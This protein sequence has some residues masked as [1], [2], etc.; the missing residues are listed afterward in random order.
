MKMKSLMIG[1]QIL[2]IIS[3]TE[4]KSVILEI[5]SPI[6]RDFTSAEEAENIFLAFFWLKQEQYFLLQ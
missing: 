6:L 1:I 5:Y 2:Q 4:V 3:L